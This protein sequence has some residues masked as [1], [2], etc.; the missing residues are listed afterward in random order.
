MSNP[1]GE[2]LTNVDAAWYHMEDP[3]NL[4]MV[5]G[6][7]VLK[8]PV[9]IDTIQSVIE[10]GLLSFDRFQQRVVEVGVMKTPHWQDVDQIDWAYHLVPVRLPGQ[11]SRE[12]LNA[13]VNA[14]MSQGLDFSQPLWQIHFFENVGQGSVLLLRV[15]HCIADGMALVSVLL[16]MTANSATSSLASGRS[17]DRSVHYVSAIGQLFRQTSNALGKAS[18]V[19]GKLIK[20]YVNTIIHPSRILDFA[21]IG[22]EGAATTAKLLFRQQDP[23]TS[24]KGELG[25]EK[26]AAWSRP[27]SLD[28][29]KT[30]RRVTG[31]TVND[32]LL[33]A[34]SGALRRYLVSRGDDVTGLDFHAAVPVNLRDGGHEITLGNQFGLVFLCLPIG[35]EDP[36]ERIFEVRARMES[37]KNS[38]EAIVSFG[39]LKAV[40]MTP[41]DIQRAIV[42]TFGIKTTCVMTN[43][44]GPKEKL[45]LAGSQLESMMFWVPLSG[46]VGLGVSILSYAGE[47]RLGIATDAGLVPDPESIIDAFHLE[48]ADMWRLY[49][50]VEHT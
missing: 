3:A 48:L 39:L 8:D 45:F 14:Y 4:M 25:I 19:T 40:G 47:V 42:N 26:R 38:P 44:P 20:G 15:H 23:T 17:I 33:A 49:E 12:D 6:I 50:D 31:S 18:K 29:V 16:S 10:R 34:M 41:V 5:S 27:V 7:I 46:R 35:I 2:P 43:V 11:G 1:K 28:R 21:K 13:Q 32:V 22:S 30:I 9:A 24:F 37:L 36:L